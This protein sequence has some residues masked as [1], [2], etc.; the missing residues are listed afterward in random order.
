MDL[1][2]CHICASAPLMSSKSC[3][4]TVPV[5][6]IR[7]AI[8]LMLT[9][10]FAALRS[11][12]GRGRCRY[13]RYSRQSAFSGRR[14]KS[15]CAKLGHLL[16]DQRPF[17]RRTGTR[18][19]NFVFGLPLSHLHSFRGLGTSPTIQ[20]GSRLPG[21]WLHSLC[22]LFLVFAP[23]FHA[24]V[25]I[26]AAGIGQKHRPVIGFAGFMERRPFTFAFRL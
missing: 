14:Q 15:F 24:V 18:S 5:L 22:L 13:G 25:H 2:N 21:V 19:T 12:P 3:A 7:L 8:W 4:Y 26:L 1:C 16:L 20:T 17:L 10:I 6:L 23:L 11:A 9:P